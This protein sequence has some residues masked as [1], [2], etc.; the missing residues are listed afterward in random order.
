LETPPWPASW[1]PRMVSLLAPA[2]AVP[3]AASLWTLPLQLLHF[4]VVPL[5]AVPA[6]LL[7]TPLLTPL[8]LGAMA[9]ALLGLLLPPLQALMLPPLA[10][11]AQALL[12][13]AHGVAALP[14]A[15]WFTGRPTGWLVGL[16]SLGLLGLVVP[17]RWPWRRR[18]A[19]ALV[20]LACVLHLHQLRADALV[21]VQDGPRTL[22]LA[23]HQG[24]GALISTSADALSCRQAARLATG[25]GLGRYD[26]LLLLDPVPAPDPT[27]WQRQAVLVRG[28]SDGPP[29]L[30]SGQFLAS[31][32]LV[33]RALTPDSQALE[34]RFG[35]ARWLLLPN[36][37]ALWSWR[38]RTE[39]LDGSAWLGFRPRPEERRLL[40]DQGAR[41]VWLSGP[42]GRRPWAVDPGW[43][44][45]GERGHLISHG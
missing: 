25:Y 34:L 23:R 35:A 39:R 40:R 36:R 32:G 13:I 41:R 22:L 21:L 24:R 3:L 42:I 18:W 37:Q 45:S 20:T 26:W 19:L 27:C 17:S 8:T 9:A 1:R 33:A 15:Q 6:N 4:G 5:W 16:F 7:A 30:A 29:P 12:A 31:P 38:Q 14:M 2:L 11:L 10:W 43:R 28:E 44:F